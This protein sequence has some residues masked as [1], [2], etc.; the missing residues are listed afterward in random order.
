MRFPEGA[1][2]SSSALW[3]QRWLSLSAKGTVPSRRDA[4]GATHLLGQP[5]HE[6]WARGL[7]SAP[8]RERTSSLLNPPHWYFS[9][10][11]VFCY[12]L[13]VISS[14]SSPLHIL[15]VGR[16]TGELRRWSRDRSLRG[17]SHLS[18]HTPMGLLGLLTGLVARITVQRWRR[19]AVR[20]PLLRAE[21]EAAEAKPRESGGHWGAA[22][23]REA[24]WRGGN[25][26]SMYGTL[27]GC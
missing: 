26:R 15:H 18:S 6:A 13:V 12:R 11:L 24:A 21:R 16:K 23:E 7:G 4:P 22:R 8:C 9:A 14:C 20:L 17:R 19:R 3:A 1:A 2:G 27:G 5:V 25:F 10:S